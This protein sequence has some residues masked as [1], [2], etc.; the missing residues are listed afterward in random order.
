MNVIEQTRDYREQ[1]MTL[2]EVLET[3]INRVNAQGRRCIDPR[4]YT[5]IYDDD[6]GNHCAIGHVLKTVL[7]GGLYERVKYDRRCIHRILNTNPMIYD[8][9][10]VRGHEYI[11]LML[12][13]LHD[14]PVHWETLSSGGARLKLDSVMPEP[15]TPLLEYMRL[16]FTKLKHYN[17]TDIAE[18]IAVYDRYLNK[19]GIV[20]S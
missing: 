9:I 7:P 5:C 12:Q 10:N 2:Q 17:Q 11:L 1:P 4:T 13:N 14:A 15:K 20:R 3:A 8:C 19:H 16:D 6:R 18:R